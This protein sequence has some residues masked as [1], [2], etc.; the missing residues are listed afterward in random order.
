MI[1]EG[2]SGMSESA[3]YMFVYGLAVA[4]LGMGMLSLQLRRVAAG[5]PL[6]RAQVALRAFCRAHGW[7]PPSERTNGSQAFGLLDDRSVRLELGRDPSAE[8]GAHQPRSVWI[9]I[10]FPRGE[11]AWPRLPLLVD[12]HRAAVLRGSR[13][14]AR[15]VLGSELGRFAQAEDL[16][17]VT[18]REV[19][20]DRF[21]SDCGHEELTMLM[22]RVVHSWRHLSERSPEEVLEQQVLHGPEPSVRIAALR[23]LVSPAR[24]PAV[25]SV[26]RRALSDASSEV[27]LEAALRAGDD[28]IESLIRLIEPEHEVDV[29]LRAFFA[30]KQRAPDRLRPRIESLIRDDSDRITDAVIEWV[31]EQAAH[32]SLVALVEDRAAPVAARIQA[33]RLVE[34]E[35]RRTLSLRC[36]EPGTPT[37]LLVTAIDALGRIGSHPAKAQ[38][39]ALLL[40]GPAQ[41]RVRL[42]ARAALELIQ[43]RTTADGGRLS[44]VLPDDPDGALSLAGRR[45][46]V[47]S[48]GGRPRAPAPEPTANRLR[49]R[50]DDDRDD[51]PGGAVVTLLPD[52]LESA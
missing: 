17:E 18:E 48:S 11:D 2:W 20:F 15:A 19:R 22:A 30:L 28:G 38:L 12:L 9:R 29:R 45:E 31:A 6:R 44:L 46:Q 16:F 33:L 1:V 25:S 49:Q 23:A 26:V 8:D 24:A 7:L 52:G 40:R 21:T 47:T 32:P 14:A 36:L 4:P 42:A 27:R 51:P 39:G 35:D 50:S 34:P 5:W 3:V 10:R 41:R 37:D 43:A 13:K